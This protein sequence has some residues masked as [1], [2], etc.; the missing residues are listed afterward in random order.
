MENLQI[1]QGIKFLVSDGKGVIGTGNPSGSQGIAKGSS[2]TGFYIQSSVNFTVYFYDGS[3]WAVHQTIDTSDANYKGGFAFAWDDNTAAYIKTADASHVVYVFGRDGDL[4]VDSTPGD[5]TQG[6][7][8]IVDGSGSLSI[9]SIE[10]QNDY[11]EGL[12]VASDGTV[13]FDRTDNNSAYQLKFSGS[14]ITIG[15]NG[16]DTV[17]F[18]GADEFTSPLT[19]DG[20]L[21]IQSGSADSR[22][23]IGTDGQYLSVSSGAPAW[24]DFS[25][26]VEYDADGNI[27]FD[28]QVSAPYHTLVK[29]ANSIFTP[30]FDESNNIV[31][32]LDSACTFANPSNLKDGASY[33]II[34]K[35]DA[36]GGRVISSFGTAYKW[37]G[38][39]APTLSASANAVDILTFISDG[40]N[41]YGS[42]VG[43]FQ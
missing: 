23:A 40:T 29:G 1:N 36:S 38:G 6:A 20:D 14:G 41:L 42:F 10:A 24:V 35:Q 3:A 32:T 28:G 13:T 11:T 17:T 18:T 34:V 5:A 25:S 39:T 31:T 15:K 9:T 16:D 22:L 21:F 4:K 37:A 27:A 2:E 7:D 33:T 12:S 26:V 30:D 19:T 8:S 43:D